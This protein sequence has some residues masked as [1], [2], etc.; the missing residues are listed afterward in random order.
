MFNS[1]KEKLDE[2]SI[3]YFKKRL[4]RNPINFS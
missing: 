4:G 2:L 1:L 3:A